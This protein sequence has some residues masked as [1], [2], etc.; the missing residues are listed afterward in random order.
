MD[1][2]LDRRKMEKDLYL[3]VDSKGV[4]EGKLQT[5]A[6]MQYW[7]YPSFDEA[8]KDNFAIGGHS[9]IFDSYIFDEA[10]NIKG[11]KYHDYRGLDGEIM[12]NGNEGKVTFVG[13]NIKDPTSN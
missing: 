13:A 9:I 12:K 6:L 11:F 4:W 8:A 7:V 3:L 10:K 5:G 1:F 2:L